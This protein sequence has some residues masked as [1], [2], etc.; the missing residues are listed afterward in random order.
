MFYAGLL[1]HIGCTAW[2]HETAA[3]VGGDDHDVLRTF[4]AV[5]LGRRAVVAGGALQLARTQPVGRRVRAIAGAIA[6]STCVRF[7]DV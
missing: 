7:F 4:E 5:D 1:R 3:R 2:A 6:A